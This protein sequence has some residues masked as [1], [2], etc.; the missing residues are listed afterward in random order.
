MIRG[1]LLFWLGFFQANDAF[2]FLPFATF[3]EQLY[4]LET[5]ENRSVFG[6][7]TTGR[8]K[9]IVLR[10][11]SNWVLKAGKLISFRTAFKENLQESPPF[12]QAR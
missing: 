12:A 4:A 9:G 5:F 6:S 2:A 8:F 7:C 3:F 11:I 10:H 1:G